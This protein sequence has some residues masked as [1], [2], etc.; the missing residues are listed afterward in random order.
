MKNL[1][2]YNKQNQQ[3]NN[4]FRKK[5]YSAN[6]RI[7]ISNTETPYKLIR[8]NKQM[9]RKI[10]KVY[11]DSHEEQIHRSENQKDQTIYENMCKLHS[12]EDANV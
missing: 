11:E 8:K 12:K 9:N 1:K 10:G 3:I 5:F 4:I 6:V 7:N 2:V